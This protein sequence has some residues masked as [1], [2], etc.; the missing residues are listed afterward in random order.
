MTKPCPI[1][2]ARVWEAYQSVTA[3]GG[4]AGIGRETLETFGR[5]PGGNLYKL[6]S[7]LCSGSYFPPPVKAVPILKKSGGVRE[8]GVP[9]VAGWVAQTVVKR[10]LEPLRGPVFPADSVGLGRAGR[11]TTR[12]RRQGGAAGT[13]TGWTSLASRDGSTTPTTGC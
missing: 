11:R 12:W 9:T 2:K 7:R 8:L 3:N 4:S 1:P 5:R 6:W 10:V 13:T